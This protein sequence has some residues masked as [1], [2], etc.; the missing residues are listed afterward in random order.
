MADGEYTGDAAEFRSK[1]T[2]AEATNGLV[3]CRADYP[4]GSKNVFGWIVDRGTV[5]PM[6]VA[7]LRRSFAHDEPGMRFAEWKCG[8]LP[9]EAL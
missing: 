9:G 8:E 5:S 3:L 1:L 4:D 2:E 7:E 6:S